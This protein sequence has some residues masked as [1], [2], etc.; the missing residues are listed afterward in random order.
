M[1]QMNILQFT[2]GEVL[3]TVLVVVVIII[4]MLRRKT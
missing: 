4:V 1:A 2:I 3:I